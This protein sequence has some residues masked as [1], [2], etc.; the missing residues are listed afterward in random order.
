MFLGSS[1]VPVSL[2]WLQGSPSKVTNLQT[3]C[4]YYNTLNPKSLNPKIPRFL[5]K[6]RPTAADRGCRAVGFRGARSSGVRALGPNSSSR[7]AGFVHLPMTF[8]WG[9]KEGLTVGFGGSECPICLE[10][11]ALIATLRPLEGS[12]KVEP[13]N[14]TLNSKPETLNP[15]PETLNPKP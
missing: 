2:F 5:M 4:P 15:K 6:T 13:P 7:F 12:R 10:G 9:G 3:G 8:V 1:V 14:S 11:G